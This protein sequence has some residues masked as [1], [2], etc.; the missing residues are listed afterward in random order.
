MAD[1]ARG[2]AEPE[3]EQDAR[4]RALLDADP[5]LARA[6]ADVDRTLIHLAM[7]RTAR[8]RLRAGIGLF[9]LA[10]RLSP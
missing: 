7:L 3:T 9:K 6:V 1:A 5:D 2:R 4:V 8:E 10:A